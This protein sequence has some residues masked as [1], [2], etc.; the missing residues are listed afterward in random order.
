MRLTAYHRLMLAYGGGYLVQRKIP[1]AQY[2]NCIPLYISY[3]RHLSLYRMEAK[4]VF[5]IYPEGEKKDRFPFLS[6]RKIIDYRSCLK[7]HLSLEFRR[8]IRVLQ[9]ICNGKQKTRIFVDVASS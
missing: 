3:L 9:T 5:S 4:I 1:L 8:L 6:S 7:L 2:E